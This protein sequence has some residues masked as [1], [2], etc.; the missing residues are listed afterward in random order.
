MGRRVVRITWE[1]SHWRSV[2]P[3]WQCSCTYHS[4]QES[5]ILHPPHSPDLELKFF[6]FNKTQ[7]VTE[8]NEISWYQQNSRTITGYTCRNLKDSRCSQKWCNQWAHCYQLQIDNCEGVS[9]E[10]HVN[11]LITGGE[12]NIASNFSSHWVGE[13]QLEKQ[14]SVNMNHFLWYTWSITQLLLLM[15][16]CSRSFFRRKR[17]I[18]P[19]TL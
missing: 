17:E 8:G 2:S 7:A 19:V 6:Y 16:G 14:R 18:C 12:K 1:L 9:M 11:G 5:V 15:Y 3:P 10:F 13:A 4:V